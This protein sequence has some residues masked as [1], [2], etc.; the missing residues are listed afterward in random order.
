MSNDPVIQNVSDTALWVAY[1]RAL[2]SKRKDALFKDNLAELLIGDRGKKIAED[3]SQGSPNTE[4]TVVMRTV[5]IDTYIQKLVEEGIDTVLN[6][7]AGLDTRPYRM[8]LPSALKWIE[9]DYPNMIDY[10][11]EL[12]KNE[13]PACELLRVSLDLADDQKRKIFL[14]ELSLT[15]KK[16][17]V[18]TEGVVLYLSEKQVAD[19]ADDLNSF[20]SYIYWIVEYLDPSVYPYLQTAVRRAK[21][22]NAPFLFFP[23]DW[24]DFF[25]Q[26]SWVPKEIIY[27]GELGLKLKRP[28]PLPERS[29][30]WKFF[31]SKAILERTKKASG[32]ILLQNT[33]SFGERQLMQKV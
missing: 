4:W 23:P 16:I 6:L 11:N 24:F 28:M 12:L 32:F 17:A 15:S 25:K 30:L 14:N 10:K 7:G 26:K 19:L 13:K 2:E 33:L 27:H 8:N 29:F 21:L 9:V 5:A 31:V 20:P 22:Q 18:L 3:M 1:Y